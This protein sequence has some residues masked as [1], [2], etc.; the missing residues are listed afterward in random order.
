MRNCRLINWKTALA[1]GAK[2]VL[3]V[4]PTAAENKAVSGADFFEEGSFIEVAEGAD[5]AA[6]GIEAKKNSSNELMIPWELAAP[7]PSVDFAND[8]LIKW[9]LDLATFKFGQLEDRELLYV[10]DLSD[11]DVATAVI[12]AVWEHFESVS[13]AKDL[14][15]AI[16]V[17][18]NIE[19]D[20][21]IIGA[22][23]FHRALVPIE[24]DVKA[25]E[26]LLKHHDKATFATEVDK[27]ISELPLVTVANFESVAGWSAGG[28][29]LGIFSKGADSF[30]RGK[31]PF[32][33][34]D[35]EA[36]QSFIAVN[37]VLDIEGMTPARILTSE[38]AWPTQLE[39]DSGT[40]K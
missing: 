17:D 13:S 30:A 40:F 29:N 22:N 27:G 28:T 32:A 5:M 15:A 35:L 37:R 12:Q 6:I 7:V 31:G 1:L 19:N 38:A 11:H 26:F 24:F 14:K 8:E 39:P 21:D 25:Y 20:G 16:G 4:Q 23:L 33:W 2:F 10:Y 34:K 3:M 18:Y 9:G 36:V